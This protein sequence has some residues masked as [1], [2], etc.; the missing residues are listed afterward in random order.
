M[1][2]EHA[3]LFRDIVQNR[4]ITKAAFLNGVS[5][6]AASQHVTELE[7]SLEVKLLDR[8]TRP[9]TPTRAGRLYYDFCRD[10]LRRKEEFTAALG[11]LKSAV[12][13]EV[14]VASIYS[15]GLSELA[16]LEEEFSR[17]FPEAD[18]RVEY[19]R[20]E[21]V[22]EAVHSERA[23]LGLMSFPEATREIAVIPWRREEMVLAAAPSHPLAARPGV[24]P[25]DLGGADFVGFD[26]DLPIAQ[27]V[28]RYLRGQG[29]E[30]HLVMH[31]D[32]IQMMKEAVALGSGVSILPERVLRADIEQGRLAA[33]PL[34]PPPLYRPVGI[35]HRRR[36]SFNRA[37]E[38]FLQLLREAPAAGTP[39]APATSR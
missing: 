24:A 38:A 25:A 4:S 35:I 34:G 8:G 21:K 37:T 29:V 16:G 23:D 7:K 17:R 15:I 22:F 39:A 33:V 5:Q 27:E 1:N 10:V 30:V 18:L 31:F 2:F 11:H 28:S 14:R 12:E 26:D 6:S 32:N 9:L 20:P 3:K 13:G 36:H 19:L